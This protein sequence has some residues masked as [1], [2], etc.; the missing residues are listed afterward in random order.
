MRACVRVFVQSY[1]DLCARVRFSF[2]VRVTELK[3]NKSHILAYV[4]QARPSG[5][6]D[7]GSSV[8]NQPGIPL[9]KF[10]RTP[11]PRNSPED[12]RAPIRVHIT[13]S[14]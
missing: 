1:G 6:E 9:K 4:L 3:I 5:L 8:H 13:I 7:G 14:S 2:C 10:V 11:L 12:G